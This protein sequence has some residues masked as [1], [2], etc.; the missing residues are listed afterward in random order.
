MVIP[1]TQIWYCVFCCFVCVCAC[2]CAGSLLYTGFLQLQRAG[3]PLGLHVLVSHCGGFS[4][5]AQAL[6][7]TG[8]TDCSLLAQKL[9]PKGLVPPRHVGSSQTRDWTGVPWISRQILIHC[10][11]REVLALCFDAH[12]H[13]GGHILE[14][15][16]LWI[17]YSF[18]NFLEYSCH[19]SAWLSVNFSTREK[20]FPSYRSHCYFA[21][22][23]C[24]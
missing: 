24:L 12:W 22:F 15:A 9:W 20:L 13:F 8:F 14:M 6:G 18:V 21:F 16:E 3:A 2:F 23:Y 5:G 7:Y 4:C 17:A 1:E 10:T 11:T 19:L